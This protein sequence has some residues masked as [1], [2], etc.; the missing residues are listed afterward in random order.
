MST[1]EEPSTPK[2]PLSE[3][4]DLKGEKK[5]VN[6]VSRFEELFRQR[7]SINA[8]LKQCAEDAREDLLTK[9]EVEAVK[10]I[11]KWRVDDKLGAAQELFTAMHRVSRAV[12]VDLFSWAETAD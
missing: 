4:F 11:A 2:K 6:Y 3:V 5:I 8:D 10:K 12:R 7:E 9:R 1:H